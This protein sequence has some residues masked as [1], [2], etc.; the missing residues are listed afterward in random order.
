[1]V[2]NYFSLES[3]KHYSKENKT[4]PHYK[5]LTSRHLRSEKQF[6]SKEIKNLHYHHYDN[7]GDI[8]GCTLT[9]A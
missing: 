2:Q 5:T 8:I 3:Q 7:N 6:R 1:M 9:F 4:I